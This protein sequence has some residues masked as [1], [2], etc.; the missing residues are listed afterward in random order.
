VFGSAA[1][2][3]VLLDEVGEL[4]AAAQA[5]LLRV[6]ESKRVMR[7][8]SSREVQVDVRVIAATH[9]D[10]EAM[11]DSGEFRRDLL[12]R[13]N[14]L[15]IEIPPLRERQADIQPLVARFLRLANQA[16]DRNVTISENALVALERYD[17]P[18][19]LRELRNAIE[20]AVVIVPT[21]EIGFDD[22]PQAVQTAAADLA[23][24]EAAES[25]RSEGVTERPGTVE[26]EPTVESMPDSEL[27]FKTRVQRYE[28]EVIVETLRAASDNQSEAARRLQMPLRTLVHKMKVYGIK[29]LGYGV[30]DE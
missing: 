9:R 15:T 26:D 21:E 22:L 23:P 3:T 24:C 18:G 10:L 28:T 4:P 20:R 30:S 25:L 14:A 2:G 17:W 12:Y 13:L 5:A 16:S 7:V 19:N 1:G 8:G 6:L 27:D 11:C 29:K